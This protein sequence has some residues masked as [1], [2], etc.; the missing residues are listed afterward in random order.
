M[1]WVKGVGEREAR[2]RLP[3]YEFGMSA[4]RKRVRKDVRKS[5]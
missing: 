4:V 1:S 3:T 5:W 2:A